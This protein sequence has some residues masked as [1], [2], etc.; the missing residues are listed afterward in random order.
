MIV[1]AGTTVWPVFLRP[2]MGPPMFDRDVTWVGPRARL[3]QDVNVA[4]VRQL[5]QLSSTKRL[6]FSQFINQNREGKAAFQI[7]LLDTPI[8]MQG[9]TYAV[10][11]LVDSN[12]A[13]M[14]MEIK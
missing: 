11:F 2:L 8:L 14:N 13:Q 7:C 6:K 3:T 10:G 5:E 9:R 4:T 12:R 1:S